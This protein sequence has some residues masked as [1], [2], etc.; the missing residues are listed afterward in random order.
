M[1]F[2]CLFGFHDWQQPERPTFFDIRWCRRCFVAE[3]FVETEDG[4]AV[5]WLRLIEDEEG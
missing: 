4:D 1:S 3:R 5:E 2:R